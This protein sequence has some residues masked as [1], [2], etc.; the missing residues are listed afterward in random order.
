MARNAE[1]DL[2]EIIEYIYQND[3]RTALVIMEK[4]IAKIN[5]LDH[6]PNRGGYI[7]ELLARNVKEYRQITEEPWKI[8]YK[9]DDNIVNGMAI[10]DS[11]G[12][13]LNDILINK[14]YPENQPT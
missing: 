6:F 11:S 9:V 12:R 5:T 4:I 14:L 2:N 8:Y 1:N 7:P 13:N 10:I 3:P